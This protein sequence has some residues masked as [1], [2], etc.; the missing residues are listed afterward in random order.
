MKASTTLAI[1]AL[2]AS[3]AVTTARADTLDV[4]GTANPFYAGHTDT[5]GDGTLPP[6]SSLAVIP[7]AILTFRV[8][9][10]ASNTGTCCEPLDGATEYLMTDLDSL[11]G[12]AGMD[13]G[14]LGTLVGVFLNGAT[15]MPPAPNRIDSSTKG[16]GF[17]FLRLKPQPQQMFFIG[18]GR[19]GTGS[20]KLQRFVVPE[21]ATR[22][23]LGVHDGNEWY[24][25]SGVITVTVMQ[26]QWQ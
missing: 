13:H 18:D 8:T 25:N 14:R 26:T 17:G 11:T 23:F 15:P 21:G 19:Q 6:E 1:A 9:G 16:P 20:G 24:N 4:P 5:G 3:S 7:G 22:L 10:G 2:L 12:I